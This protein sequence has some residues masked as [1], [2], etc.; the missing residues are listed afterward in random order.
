MG[1][2]CSVKDCK[3]NE[4]KHFNI[5]FYKFPDDE[6]ICE[7]W[8]EFCNSYGL[9]AAFKE[10]GPFGLR[11]RRICS[12]HF[13]RDCFRLPAHKFRGLRSGAVPQLTGNEDECLEEASPESPS[14]T[15]KR[16]DTLAMRKV[17]KRYY[18]Q[19]RNDLFEVLI[20][21]SPEEDEG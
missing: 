16:S 15:D 11:G 14:A 19:G 17:E 20:L 5:S 8:V 18:V 3:S 12:N 13:T 1:R 21:K 9:T 10:S 6:H 2:T 7:K 4:T